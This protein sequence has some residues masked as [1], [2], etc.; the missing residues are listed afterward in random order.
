MSASE[1]QKSPAGR[2][3]DP[4]IEP[5]VYE[6]AVRV[7]AREGWGGFTF[8]ALARESRV[9]KPALYRRWSSREELLIR[10]IDTLDFPTA[11]DCGSLRADLLDYAEQWVEWYSDQDRPL[12][13]QRLNA[14]FRAN[15]LLQEQWDRVIVGTRV[16]TARDITRRAVARGELG[17]HV[18]SATVIELLL[19]ALQNHW[20][21]TAETA[22][23]RMRE[24][25]GE[26]AATLVD[27][28]LRGVLAVA[29]EP[30]QQGAE[31]PAARRRARGSRADIP[32]DRP[33]DRVRQGA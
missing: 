11:H 24:T 8:D 4:E 6:A 3:R 18:H 32:A 27:V 19:G 22:M 14:D 13:A 7:Y 10:A 12:A 21:Y 33:A 28:I 5:R 17:P 20:M 26:H 2:R 15:A 30:T 16:P 25:L 23:P 31:P 29:A 1:Q 9:G